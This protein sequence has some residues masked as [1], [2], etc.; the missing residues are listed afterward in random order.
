MK[1]SGCIQYDPADI[2][3]AEIISAVTQKGAVV[4]E[5]SFTIWWQ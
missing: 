4:S 5:N 1:V 3:S 2:T